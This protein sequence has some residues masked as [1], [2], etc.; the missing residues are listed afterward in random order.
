MLY[1]VDKGSLY[2]PYP[3]SFYNWPIFLKLAK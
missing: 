3:S 2:S 1:Q